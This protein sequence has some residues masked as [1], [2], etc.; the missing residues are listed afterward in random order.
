MARKPME[1]P[2]GVDIKRGTLRIR[3]TWNGKRRA[4]ILTLPTTPAGITGAANLRERV[5]GLIKHALLTDALYH[6]LFPNS[7]APL[8]SDGETFLT[9]TQRWLNSRSITEGT[10][11][12][13]K[14]AFNTYWMRPLG[15]LPIDMIT[16]E[17]LMEVTASIRWTSPGVQ[18][19]AIHKLRT[20]FDAVVKMGKLP[21]NPAQSLDLP[22]KAVKQIDP[23]EQDEADRIIAALYATAYWPS[24]IYAAFFEF[25]FFTGMRLG[26]VMALRWDAV[27]LTKRVAHVCRTVALGKVENRTKTGKDRFVL[28]NERALHALAFAKEY[29][30]RRQAGKG[31]AMDMAYCFPPSKGQP[32]IH[33]TSDVHKQWRPTLKTLGIRYRPPYNARHT[34]ATLCLM[35]GMNPSFIAKQLGHSVQMLLTTYAH[36]IES[37]SDWAQMDKLNI[38]PSLVPEETQPS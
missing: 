34:Y 15:H 25:T 13:Y 21:R 1:M 17:R 11:D 10:R 36:W 26:E 23:F 31:K 14:S 8:T 4:E 6:D 18:R 9:F 35:A 20:V 2:A 24:Q 30:A 3:F 32:F 29:A 12:N 38:G 27:D 28:L 19:N 37:K 33:Q 5:V 22:K 16:S 7:E